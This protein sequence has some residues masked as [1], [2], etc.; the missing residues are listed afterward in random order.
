M[1]AGVCAKAIALFRDE[2]PRFADWCARC[3]K[4]DFSF[5]LAA[6]HQSQDNE[7]A[8]A[9]YTQ[10]QMNAQAAISAMELYEAF[11]ETEYLSVAFPLQEF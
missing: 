9:R 4:E 11:G 5:A 7:S 2:D 8:G 6:M 3:A 1:I 10:L